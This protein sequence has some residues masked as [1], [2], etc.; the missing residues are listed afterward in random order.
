[1]LTACRLPWLP[2]PALRGG[3]PL[4]AVDPGRQPLALDGQAV[5]TV[6]PGSERAW[7]S[8]ALLFLGQ[9]QVPMG[10][11]PVPGLTWQLPGSWELEPARSV[12]TAASSSPRTEQEA[13]G[14]QRLKALPACRPAGHWS[15]P[16]PSC[17]C[18]RHSSSA[19]WTRSGE[20][21]GRRALLTVTRLGQGP[22]GTGTRA[23]SLQ[24]RSSRPLPAWALR[25]LP[26]AGGP[27]SASD[28]GAPVP[29]QLP[30]PCWVVFVIKPWNR[31][32]GGAPAAPSG[33]L[34][35]IQL[36]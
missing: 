26:S 7:Q 19:L 35:G 23:W 6:R 34:P 3:G 8:S 33:V 30:S 20:S 28:P 5:P 18:W 21:E 27:C 16:G 17:T 1:M 13:R 22:G 24:R 2:F 15:T 14:G 11:A 31:A 12:P 32:P 4:S 29:T 25:L 9:T 10:R 36:A